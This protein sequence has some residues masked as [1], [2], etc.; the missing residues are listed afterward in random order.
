[1]Q[2]C[3]VARLVQEILL[4]FCW[5]EEPLM[6][7]HMIGWYMHDTLYVGKITIY[8]IANF[9]ATCEQGKAR[10]T[11]THALTWIASPCH[12]PIDIRPLT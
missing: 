4:I 2:G 3:H 11:T 7:G 12:F 5:S 9:I 6:V 10:I 8:V 1:M